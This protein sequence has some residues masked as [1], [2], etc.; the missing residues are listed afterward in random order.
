MDS[1]KNGTKISGVTGTSYTHTGLTNG[2][3]YYYV[4]TAVKG[5]T[6]GLPSNVASVQIDNVPP[7]VTSTTPA[8]GATGVSTVGPFCVTFSKYIN[9]STLNDVSLKDSTGITFRTNGTWSGSGCSGTGFNFPSLGFNTTYTMTIGTGVQDSAG[10]GLAAPYSFSF[11]TTL[12]TPNGLTATAGT[13]QTDLTWTPVSGATSYNIYWSNTTAVTKT[14]SIKIPSGSA[15]T[16]YSHTNLANGSTYVYRVAAVV[17][18]SESDLSNEVKVSFDTTSPVVSVVS[19]V[20]AEF[21]RGSDLIISFNEPIDASTVTS[22][23]IQVISNG[24]TVP[25]YTTYYSYADW[26]VWYCASALNYGTTY[27]ATVSGVKDTAGNLMAPYSWT[28][29]T[30]SLGV[31]TVTATAGN[32]GSNQITLNWPTVSG[33]TTYTVYWSTTPGVTTTNGAKIVGAMPPFT[34][35]GLT[36]GMTYYYIVS[37]IAGPSEGAAS[38]QVSAVAP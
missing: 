11:T 38:M 31:P 30:V 1:P 18:S 10:N 19:S 9:S 36:A 8:N 23:A 2:T 7:T 6:E 32:S 27:T 12:A 26:V 28:F 5:T 24:V 13:L 35:S 37:A 15:A 4:V 34:H 17:G 3:T 25:G 20:L 29:T 22:N 16:A 14:N 21:P 33:A